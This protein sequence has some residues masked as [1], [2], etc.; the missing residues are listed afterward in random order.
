MDGATTSPGIERVDLDRDGRGCRSVWRSPEIAP[1]VVPKVSL[2]TGLLYTYTKP[3][4]DDDA[5]PW[6][7]TALDF[8]SGRTVYSRL[9]GVGFGYNNNYAPVTLGPDGS[10]YVGAIGGLVR[11]ADATPPSDPPPTA[12]RGCSTRPRLSLVLRFRGDRTP[13]GR[14]CARGAV[15]AWVRGADVV[16]VSSVSF[17]R[18]RRRVARDGRRPFAKVVDRGPGPGKRRIRARVRMNDGSLVLLRRAY[19]GC[20]QP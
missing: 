8:C 16:G 14:R 20:P 13:A 7:F 11:L 18:G 12:R 4:R 9:A 15:R 17:H 10:A 2:E 6:Y 19:R 3:P 1:S 5:D